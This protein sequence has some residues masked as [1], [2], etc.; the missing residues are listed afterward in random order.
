MLAIWMRL[1]ASTLAAVGL[2]VGSDIPPTV[3]PRLGGA[4]VEFVDFEYALGVRRREGA[5]KG[6]RER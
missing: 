5:A 1:K 6:E 3:A 2:V 4:G